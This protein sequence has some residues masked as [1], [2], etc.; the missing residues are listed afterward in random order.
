MALIDFLCKRWNAYSYDPKLETFKKNL[1]NVLFD[2]QRN[3]AQKLVIFSEAIDTVDAIKLAVETTEPS[4]KVLA[5]K[6]SNRDDLEQTIKE[7]FDANY[8]G[9]W[10]N[11]YQVHC[12]PKKKS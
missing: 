7:N 4:L 10:K 5:V 8:K 6:A 12:C 2:K 11:D 1:A 3:P 9:A